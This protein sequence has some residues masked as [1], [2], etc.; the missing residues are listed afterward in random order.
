VTSPL[1]SLLISLALVGA[2]LPIGLADRAPESVPC[3][4]V[5]VQ[6]NPPAPPPS[7][8]PTHGPDAPVIGGPLMATSGLAVPGGSP[9][10]PG[11]ISATSWVVADLD[12]G[13]VLGACAPHAFGAPAS[14]QKLLLAETVLPK[15]DPAQVVT[16][17]PTDLDFEPGSSAIGLILGGQ[18]TV[19]TLW[20]GLFL[21]SGNDC[22]QTLARVGGGDR[23]IPGTIADMNAEALRLGALET[24]ADTPSGLDGPGQ[25]TSAYDLALISRADFA[26]A[27]FQ[28]YDAAMTAQIPPEPPKDPHGYQIQNDN[29][30]LREYPGA[31]GG[32]VGFTDIARHT[33]V[34]AAQRN[35]RR[36]VVTMLGAEHLPVRTWMQAAALLDWG[37]SL[38]ADASVGRLVNPGEVKPKPSPSPSTPLVADRQESATS[39]GGAT[40]TRVAVAGVV[41]LFAAAWSGLIMRARR[42]SRSA[43]AAKRERV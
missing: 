24:H 16:I 27:D 6:P 4:I 20:L 34:G 35:G 37:F 19:E 12:S 18:Y 36:L 26:R 40:V 33:Y 1:A 42:R 38:P 28:R 30:L 9:A 7:P 3:P 25:A 5:H 32:K 11:V 21:N 41:V 8:M 22:A 17:T 15:L 23:G 2:P 31:I 29:T 10:L 39:T 43:R 13:A 14:V